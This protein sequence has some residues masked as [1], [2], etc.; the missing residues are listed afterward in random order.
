MSELFRVLIYNTELLMSKCD[1]FKNAYYGAWQ[2]VSLFTCLFCSFRC[3]FSKD[4]ES[5]L[6][7]IQESLGDHAWAC[8][9]WPQP[10]PCTQPD[11]RGSPGLLE[12]PP[13]WFRGAEHTGS[14]SR[15]VIDPILPSKIARERIAQ[16]T[17]S[18][19]K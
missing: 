5:G 3:S 12:Q 18:R 9:A 8:P 13:C 19:I 15:P 16:I 2:V 7:W 14:V 10:L 11:F 17:P 6:N 1:S 4:G